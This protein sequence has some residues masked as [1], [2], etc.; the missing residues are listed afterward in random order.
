ML[1]AFAGLIA[2]AIH[3][4]SGPDHV[5]A[6]APLSA[7]R[8]REAARLGLRWGMGHSAGVILVGLLA[9]TFRDAFGMVAFSNAAEWVVGI[10]LIGV[11]LWGIRRAFSKQVNDEPHVHGDLEHAHIH[12]RHRHTHAALAIGILHGFA[13]SSHFLGVVP[14]LALPTVG[15]AIAFLVAYG[16]G[17]IAAMTLVAAGIGRLGVQ[18]RAVFVGASCLAFVVGGFWL[19]S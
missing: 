16:I 6:I 18:S 1:S 19:L 11:G 13:G 7:D 3:V 8:G 17:T 4:L 9:L 10:T 2:G 5:A 15:D 14:A 12:V